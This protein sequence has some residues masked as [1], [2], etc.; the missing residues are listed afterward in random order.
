[1]AQIQSLAQ[2]LPCAMGVAGKKRERERLPEDK[3]NKYLRRKNGQDLA[4][5]KGRAE[6]GGNF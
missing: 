2:E 4:M 1:M 5:G 6:T 3:V